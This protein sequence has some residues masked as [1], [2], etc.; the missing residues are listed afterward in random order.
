M[1]I[2]LK[3]KKSSVD[4]I[5]EYNI[6]TKECVVLAGSIVSENI[7]HSEKFRGTKSIEESREG[8]VDNGIVIRDVSFKSASTAANFVTGTS[9]NGLIAWKTED[10]KTLKEYIKGDADE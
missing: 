3:N 5:A 9:T 2:Y 7:S 6:E 10:G 8:K 1:K 4:A